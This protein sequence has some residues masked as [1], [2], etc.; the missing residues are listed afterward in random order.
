[1]DSP[2][3]I[4]AVEWFFGY[5]G[6]HLGLKRVLPSLRLI[7]ACEIEGYAVANMVAK[8]EAGLLDAAPVWSD[9]KTFPCEQFRGLVDIFCASY[10]CQPFS[11]A[12]KRKGESDPRHLWPYVRRAIAI[13]RPRFCFFENVEGHVTQGLREVLTELAML[14]YRVETPTGEPTWGIFS[15]RECGSPQQ[16][17][18]VFILAIREGVALGDSLR[19]QVE[20]IN[21][22]GF[23]DE[24]G[25]AGRG[26]GSHGRDVVTELENAKGSRRKSFRS[27]DGKRQ[28]NAFEHS[29]KGVAQGNASN[30][31][32]EQGWAELERWLGE[33]SSLLA[34]AASELADTESDGLGDKRIT[35]SQACGERGE[36]SAGHPQAIP[37]S[38]SGSMAV[39]EIERAGESRDEGLAVAKEP[40]L[41]RRG[42]QRL[43]AECRP[44]HWPE[45]VA[46]PGQQ[47]HDWEPSRITL[48]SALFGLWN[49]LRS[50]PP[51]SLRAAIAEREADEGFRATLRKLGIG[52][53]GCSGELDNDSNTDELRMLG[54]G[55]YPA[56]TARAFV[57]LFNRLNRT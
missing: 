50:N 54:N 17:K 14:E 25:R 6:N 26:G 40:G 18:R 36:E 15:A 19:E 27:N 2:Q 39:P 31:G 8:M 47:Q 1:V 51:P 57:T 42:I 56:T 5:G 55:V 24:P 48:P 38:G 29:G 41:Q 53:D 7:A 33:F 49:R 3:T 35:A 20:W 16:R 32:C 13:I 44:W 21:E 23:F 46:R 22:R 37:A 10:P 34:G 28:R 9:C 12:G 11:S 52:I 4:T 30:L 45:F 43:P